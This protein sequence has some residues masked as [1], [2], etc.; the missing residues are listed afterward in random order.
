MGVFEATMRVARHDQVGVQAG[1]VK[2]GL[3][4]DEPLSPYRSE[5]AVRLFTVR[6]FTVRM[7]VTT[8][9]V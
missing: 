7:P 3:P 1:T 6:L 9:T 4:P 2:S 8:T 5:R